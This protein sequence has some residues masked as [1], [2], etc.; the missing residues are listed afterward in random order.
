MAYSEYNKKSYQT[1]TITFN[2]TQ[3]RFL[4]VT[5]NKAALLKNNIC[6]AQLNT[7]FLNK[8][9]FKVS[10][11]FDLTA[12]DIAYSYKGSLG[13]MNLE[14]I[15]TATMPFAMVKITAGT[16]KR[17]DF[18]IHANNKINQ[19]K[20]TLLYNNLKVKLLAPDTNMNGF[21]GKLIESL[22]AN[23]FIL[24]HDNPDKEGEAPRS[25]FINYARPKESP[26]FK[27]VWNTLLVGIKPSAGLDDK[28]VQAI[29]AQLTTHQLDKQNRLKNRAA[30]K[31][32]RAEKKRQKELD[33][34]QKQGN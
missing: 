10:F 29:Q 11:I 24:K 3:G 19:G 32:R 22:Y 31:Q 25:F 8:G 30:R 12:K 17:L 13:A 26:F 23:I 20:L 5:N 1:G 15:S 34:A 14:D 6:T 18:D 16:L 9:E 7:L 27:T 4:N 28:K 33:K 2:N 21:K